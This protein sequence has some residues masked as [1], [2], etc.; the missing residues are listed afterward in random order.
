MKILFVRPRPSPE[1][2]GLQHVMIVEPLEL[3]VLAALVGPGDTPVILDM[4]LEKRSFSSLL[5][6]EHPDVLCV[7]GYITH[8]GIMLEY[9]AIARTLNPQIRT[10]V[11]GVHCE[12]CP[13]DLDHPAVDFRVVRNAAVVFPL[14]LRHIRGEGGIPQGVLVPGER[15]DPAS[16]PPFDF[17]APLPLRSLTERYRNRYFYIFHDRVALLK[18]AFG[19]PYKCTFCFCRAITQGR[20]AERPLEDVMTEL[21]AIRERE[22]YIVDDDFLVDRARVLAFIGENRRRGLDKQYLLYGRADFIARNPDVIRA[23]RSSGSPP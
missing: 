19:C 13:G 15:V 14:L 8:V 1:T 9:C 10:V 4:I 18:T 17:A 21:E 6:R 22:V 20:Y 16:L 12:V 7:T 11:G 3:E 23:F 2:I 5:R